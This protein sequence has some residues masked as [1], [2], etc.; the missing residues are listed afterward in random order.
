MDYRAKNFIIFIIIFA[1]IV[2]LTFY[3][4]TVSA[5]A[6]ING[7]Q[8]VFS[9]LTDYRVSEQPALLWKYFVYYWDFYIEH[10]NKLEIRDDSNFVLKLFLSTFIPTGILFFNL[11]LFRA[12]IMDFRPFREKEKIHGDAKWADER[13]IKKVGLRSKH[14]MLLGCDKRGY[15]IAD[16]YQHCLLFAPTGAGKGVGFVIPNLLFWQDSVVVHDIKLEN[17]ELT[18][19]YRKEKLKQ[20][21]YL[22]NPASPEGLKIGRASCRERV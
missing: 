4:M 1:I 6:T 22:W 5:I 14:G 17:Y 13:S 18:S 21:T 20:E 7:Y 10:K 11:F 12:P 16:G 2:L 15:L 9:I 3:A 19:G 8:T